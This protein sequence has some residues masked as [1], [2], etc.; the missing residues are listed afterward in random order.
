MKCEKQYIF[1]IYIIEYQGHFN[2]FAIFN[3]LIY[4]LGG[5]VMFVNLEELNSGI[6]EEV[7]FSDSVNFDEEIFKNTDIKKLEDTIVTGKIYKDASGEF[8][9]DASIT[10]KM[11]L[12][13]SI[14]LEDIVYPFS[15]N[16]E[17][18]I[19]EI[20]GNDENTIDILPIL[21]QNIVLEVPLKYTKVE[22]YSN[23]SGDGWKLVS[24]KDI[25][26]NNPFLELKEK[27]KE[28]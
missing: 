28:E 5:D 4:T 1:F 25:K 16:I 27:Y 12:E 15:V 18:N 26:T 10:G 24:E 14:S 3:Y 19:E 13:D 21:W 17:E 22:D 20:L 8:I 23:Y 9:I 11:H 2:L 6:K 7:T